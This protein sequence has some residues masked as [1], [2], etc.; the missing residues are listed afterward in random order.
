MPHTTEIPIV[1]D[2]EW[3]SGVRGAGVAL[4]VFDGT[5]NTMAALTSPRRPWYMFPAWKHGEL[6]AV[7]IG[8]GQS[9]HIDVYTEFRTPPILREDRNSSRSVLGWGMIPQAGLVS[10]SEYTS[11]VSDLRKFTAAVQQRHWLTFPAQ[12]RA[13]ARTAIGS[14]AGREKEN[15]KTWARDLVSDVKRADD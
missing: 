10:T 12:L 3:E 5:R 7:L 6:K 2:A 15:V 13:L 14:L 11:I 4:S 8:H 1:R 9:P